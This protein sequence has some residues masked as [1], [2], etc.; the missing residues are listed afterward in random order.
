MQD[1]SCQVPSAACQTPESTGS[2]SSEPS[3][4]RSGFEA[5]GHHSPSMRGMRLTASAW[6]AE[7]DAASS[8]ATVTQ[9]QRAGVESGRDIGS[10]SSDV[11]AVILDRMPG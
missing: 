1:H 5:T 10:A 2:C 6:G 11:T 3:T 8:T 4:P 7:T 9:K